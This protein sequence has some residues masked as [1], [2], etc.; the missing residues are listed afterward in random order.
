MSC[1]VCTD[2]IQSRSGITLTPDKGKGCTITKRMYS[3]VYTVVTVLY[4]VL[5]VT[6]EC[7]IVFN[8]MYRHTCSK[9]IDQPGKVANPARGQ[10]KRENEYFSVR[11]RA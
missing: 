2:S 7:S 11:V 1:T 4:H 6:S 3:T 9:S 8:S 5:C 10:V